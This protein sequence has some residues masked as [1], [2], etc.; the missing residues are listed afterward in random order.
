[1][2]DL[3]PQQDI[4]RLPAKPPTADLYDR[5]TLKV[6]ALEIDN[7]R[8]ELIAHIERTEGAIPPC[9]GHVVNTECVLSVLTPHWNRSSIDS[10]LASKRTL[11]FHLPREF[12]PSL[13]SFAEQ[14]PQV[15]NHPD[16][17]LRCSATYQGWT[18]FLPNES[19]PIEVWVNEVALDDAIDSACEWGW[20]PVIA[21]AGDSV[22]VCGFEVDE[23]L[24]CC[25]QATSMNARDTREADVY[26]VEELDGSKKLS[27]I[28]G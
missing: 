20:V 24:I 4:P 2:N 27:A 8:A 14:A 7:L 12:E 18:V 26:S 13:A 15:F 25:T 23:V 5:L 1:M 22:A 11:V 6:R 28:V 9:L 21:L 19:H 3:S 16:T 10:I 17:S